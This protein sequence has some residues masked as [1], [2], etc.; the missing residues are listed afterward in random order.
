MTRTL[1]RGGL[2]VD[3][4]GAE[5]GLADITVEDGRLVE[6]GRGLDGDDEVDLSG[7]AVL[8]GLFDCHTHVMVSTIDPTKIAQTPFSYRWYQAMENLLATLR[9]GITTVRD[10]GGADLGVKQ[11]V[12]DGLI[13]GPDS[14]SAWR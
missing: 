2:V 4:T 3:G 1:F 6:I 10:A 12:A 5:A 8:P 13:P 11:A 7:K 14:R 9:I